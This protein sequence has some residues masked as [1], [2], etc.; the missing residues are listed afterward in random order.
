MKLKEGWSA[1]EFWDKIIT[2]CLSPLVAGVIGLAL[3]GIYLAGAII[4][5][6]ITEV[7][8]NISQ[9]GMP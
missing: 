3:M 7:M 9:V 4:I 8:F 5:H 6:G 1:I 2:I